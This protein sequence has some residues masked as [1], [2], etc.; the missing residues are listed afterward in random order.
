MRLLIRE[1]LLGIWIAADGSD[2]MVLVMGWVG[3]LERRE[4]KMEGRA[5]R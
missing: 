1:R 2:K 4:E 3:I 5:G